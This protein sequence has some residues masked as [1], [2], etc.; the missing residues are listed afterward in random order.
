MHTLTRLCSAFISLCALNLPAHADTPASPD[1]IDTI[2]TQAASAF[3]HDPHHVGLS[4]GIL[5]DGIRHTY[6]FGTIDRANHQLPTDRTIYEI[7]SVTKT[8]TGILL[9]QAVMDGKLNL[10]DDVQ[11][12][13]PGDFSNLSF[14]GVPVQIM[15][16]ANHTAGFSKQIRAF[17]N[18]ASPVAILAS[19]G[20]YSQAMFLQDLRQ[21]K[22]AD[23]PGTRFAYSNVDAQLL[24]IILEKVYHLS[25]E[26]LVAKY[27]ARPNDMTD[28]STTV[29]AADSGRVAVGYDGK[30]ERMPEMT[31]WRAVPAAGFLKSTVSDQLNYLQWNLDEASPVVALSHRTLFTGTDE[32]G[33]DIA[34]FW[35]TRRLPDGSREI[36]HAGGSFG[37]TSY[38]ALYPEARTGIVLLAN[39]ADASSEKELKAMAERIVA[40]LNPQ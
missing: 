18:G 3:A 36:R 28:T 25:Y 27:I 4:I 9:A 34:M 16:L 5:K 39:D 13:L 17:K 12:Y 21:V 33:D 30:G 26:Q 31:F 6:H 24:G 37:S 38:I 23:F 29:P 32:A 20:N 1:S 7:A 15:H 14:G 22:I 35:F 19:Y 2:V 8:Y 40:K 10:D 11:K